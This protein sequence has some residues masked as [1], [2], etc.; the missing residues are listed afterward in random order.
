[1]HDS[2]TWRTTMNHARISKVAVAVAGATWW[3]LIKLLTEVRRAET[4]G[5]ARSAIQRPAER[6]NWAR[7]TINTADRGPQGRENSLLRPE[8][9]YLQLVQTKSEHLNSALWSH[10]EDCRSQLIT[11]HM[12][13]IVRTNIP[14]RYMIWDFNS[15]PVWAETTVFAIAEQKPNWLKSRITILHTLSPYGF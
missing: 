6:I 15:E 13:R 1:M 5:R 3:M 14:C 4:V 12:S 7:S 11:W 10:C 8:D 9:G 2:D